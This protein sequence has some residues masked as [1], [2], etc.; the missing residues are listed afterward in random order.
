MLKV[1]IP[2]AVREGPNRNQMEAMKY[3]R[4]LS[5]GS[6]FHEVDFS[7]PNCYLELKEVIIFLCKTGQM[8]DIKNPREEIQEL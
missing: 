4:K 1:I 5:N 2:A 3:Y 7:P 8:E 6:H